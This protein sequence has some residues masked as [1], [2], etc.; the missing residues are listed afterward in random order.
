MQPLQSPT[1]FM[2][3]DAKIRYY[4]EKINHYQFLIDE[5][6]KKQANKK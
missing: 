4:Q 6:K 3:S 5:R 2:N 1:L